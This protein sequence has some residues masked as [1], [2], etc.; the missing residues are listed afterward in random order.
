MHFSSRSSTVS[1]PLSLL[2]L[3]DILG[4]PYPGGVV[5]LWSFVNYKILTK[6]ESWKSPHSKSEKPFV[7]QLPPLDVS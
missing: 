1:V 2:P 7:G 3:S 5:L 4:D 6:G